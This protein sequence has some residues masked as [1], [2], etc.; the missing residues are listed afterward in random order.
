MKESHNK[1]KILEAGE[2]IISRKGINSATISDIAKQANVANSL[3]YQYFKNKEDLLFSIAG[4]RNKE[5]L[6]QLEEHLQGLSDEASK[7]RKLLWFYLRFH[8]IHKDYS[9][10]LILECLSSERFYKSPSYQHL[11]LYGSHLYHIIEQGIEHGVFRRDIDIR[12]LRYVIIGTL[13]CEL[14][15]SIAVGEI[16]DTVNDLDDIMTLVNAMISPYPKESEPERSTREKILMAAEKVFAQTGYTKS[17]ISKI[18]KEAG[19]SEPTVY[20]HFSNKEELL[21]AIP[22]KRF[23]NYLKGLPEIFEQKTPLRKLRRFINY[24]FSLFSTEQDFLKIFLLQIQLHRRFYGSKAFEKFENYFRVIEGI[25]E[26]GK[27]DGSFR[28]D[29]NPRIFRNMLIGTFNN[30]ELGWFIFEHG[31]KIDKMQKIKEIADLFSRA[32]TAKQ[33][34]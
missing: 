24:F 21:L 5:F 30:L 17:R 1:Q 8:D 25:V 27:A 23:E 28:P 26:E 29:V 10:V 31:T 9:R 18:A 3:I 11:R 32:V 34:G 14:I 4:E 33:G 22:E 13:G 16:E 12:L 6:T 19:I 2:E 20:D 15:S 7:L